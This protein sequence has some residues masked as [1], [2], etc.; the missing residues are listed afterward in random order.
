MTSQRV[1]G[2]AF[3]GLDWL[4]RTRSTDTYGRKVDAAA[5]LS[6]V[7]V[8][9]E[10]DGAVELVSALSELA[11]VA[12]CVAKQWARYASGIQ[13]TSDIRCLLQRLGTQVKEQDGL[14]Q[15]MLT[16]LGADWFRRGRGVPC[17]RRFARARKRALRR[18][19]RSCGNSG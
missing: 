3:E 18:A 10:V 15:M 9:I 4:G 14:N 16:F 11:A 1:V 8:D 12:D 7:G 17:P 13:E 2:F 5:A 19:A 6:L